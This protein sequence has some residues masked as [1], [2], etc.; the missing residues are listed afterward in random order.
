MY[1]TVRVPVQSDGRP[2]DFAK[3]DKASTMA[4]PSFSDVD[5]WHPTWERLM[6]AY[7]EI[8]DNQRGDRSNNYPIDL[9]ESDDEDEAPAAGDGKDPEPAS[10]DEAG[11]HATPSAYIMDLIAGLP[12]DKTLTRDQTIFAMRF[13]DACDQVWR[14]EKNG[15]PCKERQVHHILLLRQGGSG[16]T[17]PTGS[18]SSTAGAA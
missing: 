12:E 15:T 5:D 6:K 7:P 3:H 14:D 11:V 9:N 1:K 13:A 17:H 4:A 16:T 8:A 2:L 18:L 10:F